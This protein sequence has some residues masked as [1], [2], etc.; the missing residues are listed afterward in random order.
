M[1]PCDLFVNTV[2]GGGRRRQNPKCRSQALTRHH[3]AARAQKMSL[4]DCPNMHSAALRVRGRCV[5]QRGLT[6]R[7]LGLAILTPSALLPPA[8]QETYL[9]DKAAGKVNFEPDLRVRPLCRVDVAGAARQRQ[10]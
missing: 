2:R 7:S 6:R 10:R 8:A 9:A 4:G 3:A 5:R 1:C